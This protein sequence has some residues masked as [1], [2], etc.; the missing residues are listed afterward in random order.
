MELMKAA[1]NGDVN[2]VGL[3]LSQGGRVDI[4]H[5]GF[6]PLLIAVARGHTAV[7][8]LLL[9]QGKANVNETKDGFTPLLVAAQRGH[10]EICKLV[11]KTGKANVKGRTPD[12]FTA[13]LMATRYDN[14]AVC[15]L[16]LQYGSDLEE[17]MPNTLDTALHLAALSG[18]QS[19]IQLLLTSHKAYVNSRN[20]LELTP[21]H[22]ACQEG[23]LA[24]VM[25]LLLEGADPLLPQVEGAL[26]IHMAAQRNQSEVVRILIEQ[27]WCSPDL[28]RHTALQQN[29]LI[30]FKSHCGHSF[31]F[32]S[33]SGHS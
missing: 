12:G 20:Q 1:A 15:E 29:Q 5:Q 26:P 21:L 30:S 24:S 10:F 2:K 25:T 23:H 14:T 3:L 13:L 27:G 19:L 22:L 32:T 4:R 33:L 9:V 16:L 17:R 18:N 28:V 7:C 31:N 11:L 6:T 8:E